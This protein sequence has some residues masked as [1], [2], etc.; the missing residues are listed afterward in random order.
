MVTEPVEP[1]NITHLCRNFSK[2][3]ETFIYE[4]IRNL[5]RTGVNQQVIT[6]RRLLEQHR[7]YHPVTVYP[8]HLMEQG[9]LWLNKRVKKRYHYRFPVRKALKTIQTHQSQL[10]HAHFGG[11]ALAAL[12]LAKRTKLP[13]VTTFHAFDLFTESFP[14]DI[15]L[16]L[17][18]HPGAS[19]AISEEG[20]YRL[21]EYF[22]CPPDRVHILHC[23]LDLEKFPF[24]PG[25]PPEREVKLFGLGRLVE[26]KGIPTLLRALSILK[27]E[28]YIPPIRLNWYGDGPQRLEIEKL[29]VQLRLQETIRFPGSIQHNDVAKHLQQADIFVLPSQTATDGDREGIPITLLEARATGLPVAATHHAGIVEA[30]PP[31]LRDTLVPEGNAEAL[32]QEIQRIILNPQRWQADAQLGRAWIETYF[33]RATER[34]QH[35]NLYRSLIAS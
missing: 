18:E 22:R 15:Y 11:T 12:P 26:K 32:A 27:Q 28:A 25:H 34:V 31:E 35:E 23:G 13:L 7:P 4:L 24:M 21:I 30:T 17:W 1:M 5:D 9:V 16:P 14:P 19:I 10:L 33:S 6:R 20:K 8:E 29:C 3:S 2:A